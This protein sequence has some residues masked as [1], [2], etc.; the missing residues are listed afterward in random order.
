MYKIKKYEACLVLLD[1]I[2]NYFNITHVKC[3]QDDINSPTDFT[4]LERLNIY[5]DIIATS[6]AKSHLNISFPS[7][8]FAIYV[9]TNYINI[10]FQ[11]RIRECFFEQDA[12]HFLQSNYN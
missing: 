11:K 7:T 6:K 3:R 4:I 10:N 5:A 12:R 2:P 1:I 9:N 8:P